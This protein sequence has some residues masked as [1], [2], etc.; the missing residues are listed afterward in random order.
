MLETP[1]RSQWPPERVKGLRLALGLTQED[2]AH[3]LGVT[4]ATVSRWERGIKSVSRLG[5]IRLDQLLDAAR[6]TLK[7]RAATA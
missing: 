3:K 1:T 4:F 5:A 6:A 2:F 7:K